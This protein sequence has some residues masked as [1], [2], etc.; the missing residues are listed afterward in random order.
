[1]NWTPFV[2]DNNQQVLNTLAD[3]HNGKNIVDPPVAYS[4]RQEPKQERSNRNTKG[5]ENGPD[6]H[7]GSPF[8]LEERLRHTR[9]SKSRS[10]AD[11]ESGDGS[12]QT[13][14]AV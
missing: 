13:H 7:V 8:F 3:T 6:A 12:T 14:G 4:Q 9:R 10:R 1:M 11:E 5:N 2:F